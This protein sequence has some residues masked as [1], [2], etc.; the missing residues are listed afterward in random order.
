M[1]PR[2]GLDGCCIYTETEQSQLCEK[3]MEY[4]STRCERQVELFRIAEIARGASLSASA[5]H[6]CALFWLLTADLLFLKCNLNNFN[7]YL[8]SSK[9]VNNNSSIYF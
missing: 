8:L 5:P 7:F 2:V 1:G 3:G 4:T 9:C 6:S